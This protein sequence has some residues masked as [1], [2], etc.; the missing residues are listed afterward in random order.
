MRVYAVK[1]GTAQKL[2]YV[3]DQATAVL[4]L[5]KNHAGVAQIPDFDSNCLWLGHRGQNRIESISSTGSTVLKQ[6]W[7]LGP[8]ELENLASNQ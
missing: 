6:S 3:C 2:G 5:P 4:E 7:K 8:G 1:F